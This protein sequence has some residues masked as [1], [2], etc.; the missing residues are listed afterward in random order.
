[1][2][3]PWSFLGAILRLVAP[4]IPDVLS[5]IQTIRRDRLREAAHRQEAEARLAR[6]EAT[7]EAYLKALEQLT[8]QLVALQTSI[9]GIL[10]LAILALVLAVLALALALIRS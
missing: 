6:V 5:T 7:Q 9:R 1:M 4:R 2:P 8:T 10:F 3:V